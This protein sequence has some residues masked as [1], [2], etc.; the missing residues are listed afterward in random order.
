MT[1]RRGIFRRAVGDPLSVEYYVWGADG[2]LRTQTADFRVA[3]IV[4]MMGPA[5]DRD[6]V[7]EY[8][9]ITDS[10][11]IADWDPP[12]PID[13]ERVRPVDEEYWNRYRATP[14]AFIPIERGQQLW[15]SR[16]GG[17]TAL[18]LVPPAGIA[19]CGGARANTSTRCAASS[20][21]S[22][23]DSPCTTCA[24]RGSRP[25]AARPTSAST[26]P[27]SA[28]FWSSRRC[29]SRVCFS[30]SAS[31]SGCRKSG[32]C[33]RSGLD[34]AA[35]RRLFVGEA[36]VLAGIGGVVGMAGAI[37]YSALIMLGLRTWWVDAVGTTALTLHVDPLSLIAGALAVVVDRRRLD[38]VV[39][40]RARHRLDPLA[41]V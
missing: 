6:L 4:P 17:L 39:A 36:L 35:I 37:A 22:R 23:W 18:R 25:R 29:C 38:L 33:R 2:R 21:R 11:R 7:P 31:S 3:R 14:K 26:S 27:T 13:L 5:A 15:S 1:G 8:P 9:G 16:H 19:A 12:F 24:R 10:D 32:C 34:P 30:S 41:A 20:I 28:S 40:P